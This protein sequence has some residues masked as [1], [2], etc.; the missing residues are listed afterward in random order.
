MVCKWPFYFALTAIPV[1]VAHNEG[2]STRS[3]RYRR[4]IPRHLPSSLLAGIDRLGVDAHESR[5]L[6]L[7][8]LE[9][10]A[11]SSH[12]IQAKLSGFQFELASSK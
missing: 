7:A 8:R 9:L 5:K 12:V 11:D 2:M 6:F 1:L 10:L 3:S 4:A